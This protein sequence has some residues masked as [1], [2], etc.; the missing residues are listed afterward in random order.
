LLINIYKKRNQPEATA[1]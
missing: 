1:H